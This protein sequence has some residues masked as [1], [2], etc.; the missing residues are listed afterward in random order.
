MRQAKASLGILAGLS[1]NETLDALFLS[2]G[3]SP[4]SIGKYS[5]A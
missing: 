2:S 1:I 5:V 3:T 4:L